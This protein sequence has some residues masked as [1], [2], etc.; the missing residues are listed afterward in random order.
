MIGTHSKPDLKKYDANSNPQPFAMAFTELSNSMHA[1]LTTSNQ[2][3]PHL[4]QLG[5]SRKGGEQGV[6]LL[7]FM[8]GHAKRAAGSCDLG[9]EGSCEGGVRLH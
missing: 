7:M 4:W 2:S 3:W 1:N 9:A 5:P 8:I 6:R